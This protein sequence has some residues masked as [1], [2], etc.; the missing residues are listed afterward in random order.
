MDK[1]KELFSKVKTY[2]PGLNITNLNKAY[3]FGVKAHA[4]QVRDSGSPFF[5][6]P[7][8]VATILAKMKLDEKSI[9]TGLLHD[10]IEDTLATKSDIERKFGSE[11][12][13]LVDGV[14]KLS[15][16][17]FSPLKNNR[18]YIIL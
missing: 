4:D 17:S 2:F 6:H 16:I 13:S 10:V 9:I 3:N 15:K 8:E 1:Q 5:S 14:T 18:K 7:F 12:A 11:V